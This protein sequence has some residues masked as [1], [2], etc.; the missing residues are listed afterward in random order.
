MTGSITQRTTPAS[1]PCR[2]T[3]R[4]PD[5]LRVNRSPDLLSRAKNK[6]PPV[7]DFGTGLFLPC[8]FLPK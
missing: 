7:W 5:A 4:R 1:R 3:V 6:A 8:S 2:V